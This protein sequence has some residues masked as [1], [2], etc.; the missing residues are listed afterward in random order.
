MRLKKPGA[1]RNLV[2]RTEIRDSA[3][4]QTI[5]SQWDL[6]IF[7]FN[8]QAV[9]LETALADSYMLVMW[10]ASCMFWHCRLWPVIMFPALL[11]CWGCSHTHCSVMCVVTSMF[12]LFCNLCSTALF[13]VELFDS[14]SLHLL[15]LVSDIQMKILQELFYL[16]PFLV[17]LCCT[18]LGP[19]LSR[20][21]ISF[22][23]WTTWAH[24]EGL[25]LEESRTLCVMMV[26]L[27]QIS[28]SCS[29]CSVLLQSRG[30]R[31]CV[32]L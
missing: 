32:H 27:L 10:I 25:A 31:G 2:V 24:S 14:L 20:L 4:L 21:S 28:W 5:Q 17:F 13:L 12:Y 22:T 23:D 8:A 18:E 29:G 3:G 15:V 16:V 30:W 11:T 19:G 1:C 6:M 7:H 9:L 26:F